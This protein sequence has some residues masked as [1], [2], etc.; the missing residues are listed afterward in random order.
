MG[1]PKYHRPNPHNECSDC[2]QSRPVRRAPKIRHKHGYAAKC[3]V[4]TGCHDPSFR[5]FES[6]PLFQCADADVDKSIYEH[7]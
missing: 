5:A 6:K 3:N 2:N 1:K 7:P 4:V